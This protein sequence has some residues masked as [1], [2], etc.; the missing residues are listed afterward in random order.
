MPKALKGDEFQNRYRIT[1]MLK[2][3][4]P[5][6]IGSGRPCEKDRIKKRVRPNNE[7]AEVIPEVSAI[8]KDASGKPFLPGSALKGVLRHWLLHVL[9]AVDEELAT[10]KKYEEIEEKNSQ[11]QQIEMLRNDKFSLLEVV[12]GTPLHEGKVEIWDAQCKLN[13]LPAPDKLLHWDPKYLTYVDTSVAINP[14]TGTAIERL[15]YYAEVVPP[16]VE[17]ELTITGQ[18]LDDE[19][20]GLLLFGLQGF[21]SS[22]YPIRLGA[23]GGRGFGR[24]QFTPGPVYFMNKEQVKDWAAETIRSFDAPTETTPTTDFNGT[25][26]AGYFVLP[27]LDVERQEQLIKQAKEA[28][29]AKL[30]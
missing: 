1:G 8:M 20:L 10:T 11:E 17:F 12:F 19:E 9:E 24:L 5:L 28:F 14:E 16:G 15:L 7:K 30:G 29:I 3:M 22:I 26:A 6:H 27:E 21:N 4:S 18:N 23:R 25:D 13:E 2:T